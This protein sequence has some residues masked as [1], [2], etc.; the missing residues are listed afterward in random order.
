M[1]NRN[2]HFNLVVSEICHS[3]FFYGLTKLEVT[4][5]LNEIPLGLVAGIKENKCLGEK[6]ILEIRSV[7]RSWHTAQRCSLIGCSCHFIIS[8]KGTQNCILAMAAKRRLPK[9]SWKPFGQFIWQLG[10]TLIHCTFLISLVNRKEDWYLT[11]E[12]RSIRTLSFL[13]AQKWLIFND[14][15]SFIS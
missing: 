4:S 8:Y 1:T 11:S 3:S 6:V 13:H 12:S 10:K 15:G 9:W 5:V 14:C 2:L 7:E